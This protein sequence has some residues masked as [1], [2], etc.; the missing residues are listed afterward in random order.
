MDRILIKD[1]LLR[2]IIGVNDDE[3]REKQDVLINIAISA[4]LS[5]PGRTDRF[6]DTIDYRAVK[7]RVIELVESSECYLVEAL[8]ERIA[9]YM[10]G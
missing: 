10:P 4:D 5:K 8:A 2:A 7:K 3:R 6:E 1:L 9:D